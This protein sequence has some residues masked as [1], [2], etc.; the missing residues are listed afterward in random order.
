MLVA[1]TIGML[2]GILVTVATE[3]ALVLAGAGFAGVS[4]TMVYITATLW[5]VE[6]AETR[7]RG[8]KVILVHVGGMA[9][10]ALG[11]WI[12]F[13]CLFSGLGGPSLKIILGLPLL[14]FVVAFIYVFFAT[15]SYR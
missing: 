2:S 14:L 15:D 10:Y 9:G 12:T 13:G 4:N 7:D 5:Q 6:N 11:T 1:I 3:A 8:R